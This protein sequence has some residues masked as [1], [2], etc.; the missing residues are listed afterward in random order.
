MPMIAIP[1][2]SS[3]STCSGETLNQVAGPDSEATKQAWPVTD[4]PLQKL[5]RIRQNAWWHTL[6]QQ[7]AAAIKLI[8]A[9]RLSNRI[10]NLPT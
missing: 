8:Q 1:I 6:A 7:N 2:I 4:P 10:S 9:T 5:G 3:R